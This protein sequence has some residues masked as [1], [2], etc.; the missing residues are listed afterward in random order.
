MNQKML[1]PNGGGGGATSADKVSCLDAI[2]NTSDVQA[3]LLKINQYPS[4]ETPIGVWEDGRTI[5]KKK[6]TFTTAST[7]DVAQLVDDSPTDV[8]F[9]LEVI[10]YGSIKD[11]TKVGL[12][13]IDVWPTNNPTVVQKVDII[14]NDHKIKS[15]VRD[16]S[17]G[18]GYLGQSGMAV[19]TYVKTY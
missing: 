16:G 17:G 12:P 8:D 7:S 11:G 6:V 10:G 14:V 4:V 1:T 19:V 3:E 13:F 2:G 15:T 18:K 5:W 9:I